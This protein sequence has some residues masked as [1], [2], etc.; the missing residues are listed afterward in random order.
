MVFVGSSGTIDILEI[1]KPFADCL[2]SRGRYRD[3]YVPKRE[4]AGAVVQCEK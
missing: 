4:L 1:K 3:N 2:L